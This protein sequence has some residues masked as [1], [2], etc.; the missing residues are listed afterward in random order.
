MNP[1]GNLREEFSIGHLT[2]CSTAGR[3]KGFLGQTF[4]GSATLTASSISVEHV[5]L[6]ECKGRVD[7]E[8]IGALTSIARSVGYANRTQKGSKHNLN[9]FPNTLV[10]LYSC[11]RPALKA[12]AKTCFLIKLLVRMTWCSKAN[13]KIVKC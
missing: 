12:F 11:G 10:C 13:G 6:S 4:T 1:C 7:I 5:R 8:P 9:L 2:M 3:N